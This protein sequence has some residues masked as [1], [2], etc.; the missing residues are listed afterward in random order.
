MIKIASYADIE[1]EVTIRYIIEEISDETMSK[2]ILYEQNISDL[3]KRLMRYGAM[4][5]SRM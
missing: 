5:K 1:L 2:T 3:T 4:K